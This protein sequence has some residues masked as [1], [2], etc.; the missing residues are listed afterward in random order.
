M[1]TAAGSRNWRIPAARPGR[2]DQARFTTG[3]ETTLS[4]QGAGRLP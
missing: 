2:L 1:M 3:P 4:Q